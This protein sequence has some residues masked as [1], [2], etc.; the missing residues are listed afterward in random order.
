MT[1]AKNE[2]QIHLSARACQDIR[3]PELLLLLVVVVVL[4]FFPETGFLCMALAVLEIRLQSAGIKGVGHHARPACCCCLSPPQP[5][6]CLNSTL[7]TEGRTDGL[8]R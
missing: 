8:T 4:L 7:D 2:V 1:E 5:P 6:N 3:S